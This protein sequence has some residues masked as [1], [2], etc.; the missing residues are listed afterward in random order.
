[1]KTAHGRR[2]TINDLHLENGL[3]IRDENCWLVIRD[4]FGMCDCSCESDWVTVSERYTMIEHFS[5]GLKVGYG[6]LA[7]KLTHRT[8]MNIH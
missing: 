3:E 5:S 6:R 8:K 7:K 1:M 4:V 2:R